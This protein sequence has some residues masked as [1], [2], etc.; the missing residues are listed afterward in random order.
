MRQF[1]SSGFRIWN[2]SREAKLIYTCFALFAIL[3]LAVSMLFYEDLVGPRTAG[4]AGYYAGAQ[5]SR[6]SVPATGGPQIELAPEGGETASQRITVA[7]TYRKLLEVTHFHLF[8]VPVFLLIIAH[9]FMLTGLSSTA[10][11]VWIALGWGSSLL[12]LAAP[13]LIRYGGAAWS[14]TY[15]SSGAIMAVSLGV[16]TVY[17]IVVMWKPRGEPKQ[18]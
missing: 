3:A 13:W 8:T 11:L 14:F 7:V 10:K 9:L 15:P 16:M 18:A 2:L 17:P 5:Y 1:A 4:V 6:P 12:H